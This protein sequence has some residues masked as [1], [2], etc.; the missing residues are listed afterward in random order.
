MPETKL[1]ALVT[2]VTSALTGESPHCHATLAEAIP[3]PLP[4]A[5][6]RMRKSRPTPHDGARPSC[7]LPGDNRVKTLRRGAVHART[8]SGSDW[9]VTLVFPTTTS[10]RCMCRAAH[11]DDR[12]GTH[13]CEPSGYLGGALRPR[14]R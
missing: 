5:L 6:A 8:G 3:H 13:G 12:R 14:V 7:R 11:R 1:P 10:S 4:C 9:S 2:V